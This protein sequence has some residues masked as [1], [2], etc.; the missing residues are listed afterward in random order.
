MPSSE[1]QRPRLRPGSVLN[2]EQIAKVAV[3]LSLA[4]VRAH[5]YR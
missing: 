2:A 1:L 5:Q 3:E 4:E